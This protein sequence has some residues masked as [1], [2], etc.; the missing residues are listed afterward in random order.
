[1][2]SSTWIASDRSARPLSAS[3]K[4]LAALGGAH[5]VD[6]ISHASDVLASEPF[7]RLN[8]PVHVKAAIEYEKAAAI[9]EAPS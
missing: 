5:I 9:E 1:M 4:A 6:L 2:G 3:G 8:A 7:E